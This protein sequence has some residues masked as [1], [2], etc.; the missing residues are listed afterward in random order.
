MA[1]HIHIHRQHKRASHTLPAW[2][3]VLSY[4]LSA[5]ALRGVAFI[6][7][8]ASLAAGETAIH[9]SM[10]RPDLRTG[11]ITPCTLAKSPAVRTHK[12]ARPCIFVH[13]RTRALLRVRKGVRARTRTLH[14][15]PPT[16]QPPARTVRTYCAAAGEHEL[17]FFVFTT[18]VTAHSNCVWYWIAPPRSVCLVNRCVFVIHVLFET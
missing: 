5:R 1:A 12:N 4:S 7:T 17:L 2:I 8:H 3:A 10:I 13:T 18:D 16:V 6:H 9:R 14:P 11:H 15:R